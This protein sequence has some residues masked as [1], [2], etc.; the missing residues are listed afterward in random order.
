MI[1]FACSFLVILFSQAFCSLPPTKKAVH[2]TT[3]D[4]AMAA[5]DVC[6]RAFAGDAQA[7]ALH[8]LQRKAA[9]QRAHSK[10]SVSTSLGGATANETVWG[11]AQHSEGTSSTNRFILH[12][13]PPK[14]GSSTIQSETQTFRGSLRDD[15]V[16]VLV[17]EGFMPGVQGPNMF[18]IAVCFDKELPFICDPQGPCGRARTTVCPYLKG[19]LTTI[20][21]EN[22]ITF[23][24]GEHF[25][26]VSNMPLLA[27]TLKDLNTTIIAVYRPFY[28]LFASNHRQ[29]YNDDAKRTF[30]EY[31][32][33]KDIFDTFANLSSLAAYQ[34][35]RAYFSDVKV[36]TLNDDLVA[37]L[38]CDE[39]GANHTC[40]M[41]RGNN[42]L[43]DFKA[44]VKR[45]DNFT[46]TCLDTE[47]I[48]LLFRLSMEERSLLGNA[49]TDEMP[50]G[51]EP[52]FKQAFAQSYSSCFGMR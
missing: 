30:N 20:T 1:A 11:N 6:V 12:V 45:Q 36:L 18:P 2:A 42:S 31:A 5:E 3:P 41:I 22:R 51:W 14:T 33:R 35:Y 21:Q 26:K 10:I 29:R 43:E 49:L 16:N 46:G 19:L 28:E 25:A 15:G 7:C 13:G 37:N 47:R 27:S 23:M 17:T 9:G 4:S 40:K 8:A 44:N 50:D 24:S 38:I 34:K 32:T 39:F 52:A 48:D